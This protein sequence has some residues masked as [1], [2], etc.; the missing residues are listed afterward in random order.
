MVRSRMLRLAPL[1]LLALLSC[2][3]GTDP[4][5]PLPL[6][7]RRTEEVEAG[8]D[9]TLV[10]GSPLDLGGLLQATAVIGPGGGT[11]SLGGFT[12][13]VP[14]G[15]VTLPT[16][17]TLVPLLN[18]LVEVDLQALLPTLLGGVLD[19]GAAGF[20]EGKEVTLTMSYAGAEGVGDP[21]RLL[22]VHRRADGVLEP[23]ESRVDTALRTVTVELEHFSR[24]CMA[25]R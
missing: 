1:L 10:S 7:P 3:P 16:V 13:T 14:A 20:P 19:V 18:G 21:Q 22:I 2:D 9:L 5:G 23:L 4:G 15:A 11:L 8:Q 6:E 24:Y 17:F 25:M 12:L